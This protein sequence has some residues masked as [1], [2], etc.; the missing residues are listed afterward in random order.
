M[1]F[2]KA[3]CKR[4]W[5]KLCCNPEPLVSFCFKPGVTH[6]HPPS[7]AN[8]RWALQHT[9]VNL[10][11]CKD[12]YTHAGML[13]EDRTSSCWLDVENKDEESSWY[14]KQGQLSSTIQRRLKRGLYTGVVHGPRLWYKT[15][16]PRA[17]THTFES[18]L[19]YQ[20]AGHSFPLTRKILKILSQLC[21]GEVPVG[22]TQ[23]ICWPSSDT[24]Q[25]ATRE[26]LYKYS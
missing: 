10:S 11:L 19:P 7:F 25:G 1:R 5:Q 4:E 20:P 14:Q 22:I 26:C 9:V 24:A 23:D 6:T 8:S 2:Y 12:W 15:I 16:F 18:E 21:E 3:N 17:T 13:C